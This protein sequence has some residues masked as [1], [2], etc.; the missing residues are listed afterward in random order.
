MLDE[1]LKAYLIEVNLDPDQSHSNSVTRDI[2][3]KCI[4]SALKLVIEDSYIMMDKEIRFGI[5]SLS[6][7]KLWF[8]LL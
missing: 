8:V 1:D 7:N 2:V 4:D 5:L 3:P 6:L